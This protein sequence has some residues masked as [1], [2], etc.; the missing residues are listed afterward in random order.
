MK[1]LLSVISIFLFLCAVNAQTTFNLTNGKLTIEG[2]STM[3]DWTATTP[4]VSGEAVFIEEDGVPV[5]LSKL[6]VNT[7]AK[8]IKSE[9]GSTMDKNM[10]KALKADDHPMLTFSL[11][12]VD[13]FRKIGSNYDVKITGKLTVAGNT[14]VVSITGKGTQTGSGISFSG[15]FTLK[16]TDF[17]VEPPSLFFGTLNTGDD[18]TIRYEATFSP[19]GYGSR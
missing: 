8:S 1:Y 12:K 3:H 13:Y 17:N 4:A 9:K 19:S 16:M 18:I 10:Y 7:K 15:N 6:K 14:K 2:T 11:T 5:Q